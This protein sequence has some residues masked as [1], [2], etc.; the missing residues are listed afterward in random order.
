MLIHSSDEELLT[1]KQYPCLLIKMKTT[2][3]TFKKFTLLPKINI[4]KHINTIHVLTDTGHCLQRVEKMNKYMN[5]GTTSQKRGSLSLILKSV[6]QASEL[7]ERHCEHREHT[8]K[9]PLFLG[10]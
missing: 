7:A 3:L 10:K 1:L 8:L 2:I 5:S 9:N 6:C 4:C